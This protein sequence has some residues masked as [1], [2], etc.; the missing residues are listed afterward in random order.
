MAEVVLQ[1]SEEAVE[2]LHDQ[3]EQGAAASPSELVERAVA[4]L[5]RGEAALAA[6]IDV[7]LDELEAGKGMEV[8]DVEAWL[9]TLGR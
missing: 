9:S 2:F 5:R 8:G 1:L 4:H 7:G 6:E 3:V